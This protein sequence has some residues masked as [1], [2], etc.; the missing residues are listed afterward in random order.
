[1]HQIMDGDGSHICDAKVGRIRH[2]VFFQ[3]RDV[4]AIR[5]CCYTDMTRV[6][7]LKE[8]SIIFFDILFGND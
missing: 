8:F 3:L 5:I 1:M 7:I 4:D 2:T 6:S